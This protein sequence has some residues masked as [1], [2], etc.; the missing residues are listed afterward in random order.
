MF[1][2]VID[3]LVKLDKE[4]F[5]FINLKLQNG[6]FDF[7]MPILT[8]FKNWRI[9]FFLI[10]LAMLIFGRKK[11]RIAAVLVLIVL[12]MADSSVNLLLKSWI[13]RVRPCNVFSQVH[14]LAG[15]S[16]SGSFPSSHAANIFAA[17]S[18]LTFLYRRAWFI[19]LAI[20]VTVSFSRIY[21]G[22]H[23]PLDVVGGAFYGILLGVLV[24]IVSKSIFRIQSLSGS[25]LR[26]GQDEL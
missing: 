3:F 12:G 2:Q 15:C 8:E 13:G 16:H 4:L 9:L 6:F 22:V 7:L 21:V 17:G 24:L 1:A 19:W 18:I 20:A 26:S 11:E 10:M 5:L 14:L 23:Y 25:K